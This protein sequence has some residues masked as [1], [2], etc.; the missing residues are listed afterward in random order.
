[1]P[2]EARRMRQQALAWKRGGSA[3]LT[4]SDLGAAQ[5]LRGALRALVVCGAAP[6]RRQK[7]SRLAGR[8]AQRQNKCNGSWQSVRSLSPYLPSRTVVLKLF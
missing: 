6:H 7:A 5:P 8:G 1:M 2:T 4:Q 3:V